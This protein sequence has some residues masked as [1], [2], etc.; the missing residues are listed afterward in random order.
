MVL[1]NVYATNPNIEGIN[2][3]LRGD[4]VDEV[5]TPE[6]VKSILNKL[7]IQIPAGDT[8][9][10]KVKNSFFTRIHRIFEYIQIYK[11][12]SIQIIN[13]IFRKSEVSSQVPRCST[14]H[15]RNVSST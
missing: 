3:L 2:F 5:G 4:V 10:L 1:Q 6:A 13:L 12:H 9:A 14:A 7:F 15:A 11:L 8:N